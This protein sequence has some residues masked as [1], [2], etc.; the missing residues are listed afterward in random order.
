MLHA[1]AK[2]LYEYSAL[3]LGLGLLALM[4]LAWAPVAALLDLT[5]PVHWNR[6]IGRWTITTAFR[7]YVWLLGLLGVVRVDLGALDALE[8]EPPL[9]I[10]PNHPGLLDAV[11]ILSRLS[12]VGCIVRA[13]RLGN[14]LL[15]PGARLAGYI[16]NNHPHGMIKRAVADLR[17]GAHLL[18]F[19][20]GTRTTRRPVNPFKSSP[21]L[22]AQKAGVPLQTLFI[23][24][25]S[26][27][28][29]KHWSLFRRPSLPVSV[30]VRLG[31]RYPPPADAREFTAALEGYFSTELG[32]APQHSM[33]LQGSPIP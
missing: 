16:P 28:L 9:I 27:F 10:A 20:E 15:G 31:H 30:R 6:R 8:D 3:C 24:T 18:L 19:P 13:D 33:P 14:P 11:L 1:L 25:D 29:G 21:A 7:F 12:N 26:P 17:S 32:T 4:C 22:I 5:L 2:A 23:E